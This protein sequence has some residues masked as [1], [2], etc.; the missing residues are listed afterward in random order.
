M[1][2]KI[3]FE[4]SEYNDKYSCI[5]DI[6]DIA[7]YVSLRDNYTISVSFCKNGVGHYILNFIRKDNYMSNFYPIPLTIKIIG[8]RKVHWISQNGRDLEVFMGKDNIQYFNTKD[9]INPVCIYI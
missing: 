1:R 5:D 8:Y 6:E 7:K 9:F 2:G 4:I 3:N